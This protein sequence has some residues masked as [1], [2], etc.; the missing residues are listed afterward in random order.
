MYLIEPCRKCKVQFRTREDIEQSGNFEGFD[1]VDPSLDYFYM[2]NGTCEE[3]PF[4]CR[5]E[6]TSQIGYWIKGRVTLQTFHSQNQTS[7]DFKF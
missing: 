1:N 4:T 6:E 2:C 7:T 5:P 3:T